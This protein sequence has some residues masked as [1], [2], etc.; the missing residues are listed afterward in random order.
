M[1]DGAWTV[2]LGKERDD[3]GSKEGL[4]RLSRSFWDV[5]ASLFS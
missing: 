1:V 2:A 4:S 5:E 3:D